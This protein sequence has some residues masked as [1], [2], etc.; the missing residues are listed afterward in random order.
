MFSER[1]QQAVKVSIQDFELTFD[2]N[3][4]FAVAQDRNR[5]VGGQG[6]HVPLPPPIFLKL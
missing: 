5:G 6:G 3:L 2:G 1:W 4:T